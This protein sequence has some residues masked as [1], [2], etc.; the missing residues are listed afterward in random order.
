LERTPNF[1][2][3]GAVFLLPR[4]P[5]GRIRYRRAGPLIRLELL[6]APLYLLFFLGSA[7][8]IVESLEG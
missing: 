3:E 4:G 5:R 8:W 1:D 2:R 7:F 6:S